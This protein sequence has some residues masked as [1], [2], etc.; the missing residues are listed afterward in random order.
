M[1]ELLIEYQVL[2]KSSLEIKKTIFR[3][4]SE[5]SMNIANESGEDLAAFEE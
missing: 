4:S 1:E 2:I 3:L 5:K